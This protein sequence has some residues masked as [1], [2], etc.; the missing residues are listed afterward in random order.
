MWCWSRPLGKRRAR[1]S[2]QRKTSNVSRCVY[3]FEATTYSSESQGHVDGDEEAD[4][5]AAAFVK[6]VD[7]VRDDFY[8][9][10]NLFSMLLD[11]FREV[12]DVVNMSLDCIEPARFAF[13]AVQMETLPNRFHVLAASLESPVVTFTDM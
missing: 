12:L 11:P 4:R 3:T 1:C 7:L 6:E 9:S 13:F 2:Y 10:T 8:E 5:F